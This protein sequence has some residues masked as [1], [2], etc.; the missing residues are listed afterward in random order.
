MEAGLH[1]LNGINPKIALKLPVIQT[2]VELR[3]V[4]HGNPEPVRCRTEEL[5]FIRKI[6]NRSVI[7]LHTMKVALIRKKKNQI[8]HLPEKTANEAEYLLPGALPIRASIKLNQLTLFLMTITGSTIESKIAE[9]Q[10]AMKDII[11]A[12]KPGL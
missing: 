10:L 7:D 6:L 4:W 9:R 12:Q 1:G 3:Y 11:S 8:Q 5:G 2:Y